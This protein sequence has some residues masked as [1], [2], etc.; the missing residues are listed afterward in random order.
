M[1]RKNQ[2]H[3]TR[4]TTRRAFLSR[5][6]LAATC[7][8]A[9]ASK[10]MKRLFAAAP[11]HFSTSKAPGPVVRPDLLD[12]QSLKGMEVLQL[13]AEP[14]VPSSHVYMEAQI[15]T[16]DS[17]RFV[18]HRSAHAHGSDKRDPKHQYLLC[19]I[20]N[21]CALHPLTDEIGATGPSVSPDDKYLYYFVDQTEIGGGRLTLKRVR[22]DATDRQTIL[23]VDS[24]LPGT[25]FRPSRIY[26]LSTISSDGKRLAISAFLGDGK[27][28]GAPFGL[29]VFDVEKAA[30]HLIIHGPSWCNMHPQYCRSADPNARRDILIQENHGNACNAKGEIQKLTGGEGADIHV[31]RDDGGNFRNLPWGRDGNEFCQG[32]Q[33]WRGQSTWAIT[34]TSTRKPAEAQLIESLSAPHAGHAGIQTPGA[35]RN[36]LSR[37]FP[38]PHFYHFATDRAGNRLISDAGPL[39]KRARVFLAELGRPGQEAAKKF[40]DLLGPKS[41]CVKTAHIHPFLSPDGSLGFFNSDESGILQ[42]YMIRGLDS[43]QA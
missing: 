26:P 3:L 5:S 4:T 18:L 40:T 35:I 36:D 23:A 12:A 33:C 11:S 41:S 20:A 10:S 7:L 25:K 6:G 21:G 17:K 32:H 8:L 24:P 39:D 2:H 22:L 30:V 15:F 29:L 1:K 27:T 31:I 19:D 14:D 37:T 28:E 9:G 34:S 38:N 43:A 13:T 42:A 16:T